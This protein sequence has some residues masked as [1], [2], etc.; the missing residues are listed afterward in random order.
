MIAFISSTPYQTWNSIVMAKKLFPNEACDLFV[1][2]H[3]ENYKK[4]AYLVENE[5]IFANVYTCEVLN[6]FCNQIKNK[7]IRRT[8]KFLYFLFWKT[9]LKY[10]LHTLIRPLPPSS[11]TSLK[12]KRSISDGNASTR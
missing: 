3:C 10:A 7:F 9:Y 5:K 11:I 2:D 6:L 8:K 1:L 4:I 12:A